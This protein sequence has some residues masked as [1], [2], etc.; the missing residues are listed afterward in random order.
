MF[1]IWYTVLTCSWTLASYFFLTVF[2]LQTLYQAIPVLL[3]LLIGLPARIIQ[4]VKIEFFSVGYLIA[5]VGLLFAAALVL[6]IRKV[7]SERV[8]FAQ[9]FEMHRHKESL[10]DLLSNYPEGVLIA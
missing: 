2:A 10:R 1:P 9:L 4:L 8:V 5:F 7:G 6:A 3:M